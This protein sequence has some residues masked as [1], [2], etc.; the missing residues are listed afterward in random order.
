MTLGAMGTLGFVSAGTLFG[1][2]AAR[3]G[4]ARDL[5]LS[6]VVFPLIAPAL[7]G[8]VIA[9]RELFQGASPA[10]LLG[11]VKALLA[12]DLIFLAAG[13]VLFDPLLS[14]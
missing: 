2:L 3:S 7:L 9:T 5:V 11:W 10:E 6:L 4:Q 1:A 12:F 13:G 8:A 14:D